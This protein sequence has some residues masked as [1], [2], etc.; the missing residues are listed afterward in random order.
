MLSNED[1]DYFNYGS[2]ENKKFWKRLKGKP[3]FENKSIL[4]FGCGHGAMCIEIA[5]S[6]ASSVKGIESNI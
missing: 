3:D 5:K 4:D 6:G 2:V 1:L